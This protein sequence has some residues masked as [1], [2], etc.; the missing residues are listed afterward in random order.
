VKNEMPAVSISFRVLAVNNRM[1]IEKNQL[2]FDF[3]SL[4]DANDKNK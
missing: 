4:F 3:S 1:L 2:S